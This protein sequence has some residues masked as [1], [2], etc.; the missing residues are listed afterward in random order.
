MTIFKINIIFI[1]GKSYNSDELDKL[2]T[3]FENIKSE[4][5]FN[6]WDF[7]LDNTILTKQAISQILY[8][9][10]LKEI[11][12]QY[13]LIGDIQTS[14]I[15]GQ[16]TNLACK[17]NLMKPIGLIAFD[18]VITH[19]FVESN[20]FYISIPLRN[21]INGNNSIIY[22]LFRTFACSINNSLALA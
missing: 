9:R 8:D 16:I 2:I 7:Q 19:N 5:I 4:L 21:I 22:D 14:Y 17:K 3:F 15:V 6:I 11:D 1:N 18:S 13:I 12:N 10:I 20:I